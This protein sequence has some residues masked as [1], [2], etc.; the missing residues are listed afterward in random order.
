MIAHGDGTVLALLRE[1]I[2]SGLRSKRFCSGNTVITSTAWKEKRQ[3]SEEGLKEAPRVKKEVSKGLTEG[4][5]EVKEV[6]GALKATSTSLGTP[7]KH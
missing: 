1:K 4:L 7:W 3:R 2:C 6:S 5:Q